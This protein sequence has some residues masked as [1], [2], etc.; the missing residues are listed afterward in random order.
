VFGFGKKKRQQPERAEPVVT[1]GG[2]SGGARR[3]PAM[4]RALARM[5]DAA[6]ADRL[7]GNWGATPLTADDV[8]RKNQRIL[9]ARS[10]EQ[11]ANN[12][13][14]KRYLQMARQNVVGPRGVQLQA[15]SQDADGTLDTA[16]NAAIERAWREWSRA[17]N[18]DVT[19][20][21][22]FRALQGA[23][24]DSAARDGEFMLRVVTGAAAGP[25]GISLQMLDPQ[26]C[27]PDY[28]EI[29]LR[30]GAFIR[31]GIEF[32]RYGRPIAYHFTSTAP[33]KDDE[34]YQYGGR[35]Y[36]RIPAD[37]I[38]HGFLP[39]MTGQK[40]GLHVIGP[41]AQIGAGGDEGDPL[42]ADQDI[43]GQGRFAVLQ[44]VPQRVGMRTLVS[45]DAE[46][47][48]TRDGGRSDE[49]GTAGDLSGAAHPLT[50]L[51]FL[52]GGFHGGA[53]AR[54]G[55][56]A[57]Q[58]PTHSSVDIVICGLWHLGQKRGGGGDL[59][60]LTIAA[61]RDLVV[62]PS[63]LNRV[64]RLGRAEAVNG[65]DR[66]P[67][68]TGQNLTGADGLAVNLHGAGPA[69]CNAATIFHAF[70]VQLIAQHP[71][72]RHVGFDLN[73]MCGF[74]DGESHGGRPVRSLPF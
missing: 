37:Q 8:V 9:V 39:D 45:H 2:S 69:L 17:E 47:D 70:E 42:G 48:A 29:R 33:E 74:V 49:E 18:C 24:V 35:S 13:F 21:Q 22:S 25:W 53:D 14:A 32:N 6:Q 31:H 72:E 26:R 20:R 67:D 36:V 62:D 16:A 41:L 5:H 38:V 51:Q 43:R 30:G 1:S 64:Q 50:L 54:I 15:R 63:S 73:V 65:G 56:A 61:L 4:G 19:G 7:T 46:G 55:A 68:I 11:A 28:D 12:D 34:A 52:G 71:K 3:Q 58:I 66:P 10:R 27:R 40:R 60:G 23:A 59:P 57:A 44:V